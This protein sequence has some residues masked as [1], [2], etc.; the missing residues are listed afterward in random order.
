MTTLSDI[1]F[2]HLQAGIKFRHAVHGE[3]IVLDLSRGLLGPAIRFHNCTVYDGEMP[4]PDELGDSGAR[5]RESEDGG[6]IFEAIAAKTYPSG[7]E[8]WEYLGTLSAD[9]VAAHGWFWFH[10]DCPHCGLVHR[11]LAVTSSTEPR[12]CRACGMAFTRPTQPVPS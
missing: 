6:S 11:L 12:R 2:E 1:G 4:R 7:A 3:Q 9:D 8:Q 10:V 5:G